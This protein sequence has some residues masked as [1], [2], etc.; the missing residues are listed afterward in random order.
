MAGGWDCDGKV[1]RCYLGFWD[2][3]C[4]LFLMRSCKE[5]SSGLISVLVWYFCPWDYMIRDADAYLKVPFHSFSVFFRV[6]KRGGFFCLFSFSRRFLWPS[7]GP[8]NVK[9]LKCGFENTSWHFESILKHHPPPAF[10][11]ALSFLSLA[12]FN[13]VPITLNFFT[14]TMYLVFE[15]TMFISDDSCRILNIFVSLVVGFENNTLEREKER[16]KEIERSC[17]GHNRHRILNKNPL[18]PINSWQL[19]HD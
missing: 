2:F 8:G 12:L 7:F 16:E 5:L 17:S 18:N 1:S 3:S 15:E 6:W 13:K 4:I 14:L 11:L 9:V 10:I 19:Q